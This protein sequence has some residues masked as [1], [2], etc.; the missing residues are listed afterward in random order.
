MRPAAG[1]T[2]S[3]GY[4]VGYVRTP[5]IGL[6]EPLHALDPASRRTLCGSPV[7]MSWSPEDSAGTEIDCP[8]C[9]ASIEQQ[10]PSC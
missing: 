3:L 6:I 1:V 2:A 8:R 10:E 9:V 7:A 5:R 4:G